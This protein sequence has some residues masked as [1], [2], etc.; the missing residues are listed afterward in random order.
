MA[1]GLT[2][3]TD[4][5]VRRAWLVLA[6]AFT[7]F[8]VMLTSAGTGAYVYRSSAMNQYEAQLVTTGEILLRP[9][10]ETKYRQVRSGEAVREG[11]SI[12]TQSGMQA[13]LVFFDGSELRLAEETLI[14]VIAM[15]ASRFV[16]AEKRI[17]LAQLQGWTRLIAAPPVDYRIGHYGMVLGAM[18]IDAQSYQDTGAEFTFELRPIEP[19]AVDA[20]LE[21]RVVA[22]AGTA[23]VRAEGE[24]V[25][26]APGQQ[27]SVG[28]DARPALLATVAREYARNGDFMELGPT[29]DELIWPRHWALQQQQGNDGG[30]LDGVAKVIH[31]DVDGHAVPAMTFQRRLG[32]KDHAVTGVQQQLDLPLSHFEALHLRIELQVIHHSLSGGGFDDSEYPLIVKVTYRDRQNRVA[33]WYRGFYTHNEEGRRVSHGI[34]VQ[35]GEWYTFEQDLLRLNDGPG[36]SVLVKPEPVYLET[37]DIYAAGHDFESVVASVSI[38]GE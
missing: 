20:G 27:A 13:S 34:P 3:K 29:T 22:H 23:I 12:K 16:T 33:S 9:K 8:A 35:Q 17:E 28:P 2:L 31:R 11:D 21:A 36:S 26:L 38:R 10:N 32:A 37:L 15:R 30:D 4:H 14:Q 1:T 6:T 24:Q 7:V 18:A 25:S 19:Q 5:T